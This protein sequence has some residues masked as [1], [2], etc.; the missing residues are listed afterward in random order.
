M[1]KRGPKGPS[2][3]TESFIEEQAGLLQE[4]TLATPEG[5][6]PSVE[7]FC[8][9][10]PYSAARLSELKETN[11]KLSEAIKKI[12]EL[13]VAKVLNG[14]V[15]NPAVGIFLMKNRGWK[16]TQHLEKREEITRK[17]VVFVHDQRALKDVTSRDRT[18]LDYQQESAV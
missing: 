6:F 16:D 4:Y 7:D 18:T 15:W 10:R 2:K 5:K 3:W 12:Q 8:K 11:E 17:T 1:A 9:N 14:E 13:Q